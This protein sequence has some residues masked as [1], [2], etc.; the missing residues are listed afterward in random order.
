MPSVAE[1]A[2]AVTAMVTVVGVSVAA[3]VYF[4]D[5][6]DT[7][8]IPTTADRDTSGQHRY[9]ISD[10]YYLCRDH[11]ATAVN[12]TVRNINVDSHSSRY[13]QASNDNLVFIDVQILEDEGAGQFGS[14]KNAKVECRVS[15]SSN[16]IRSFQVRKS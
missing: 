15:A 12:N 6:S 4:S 2:T 9:V 10:A 3:T 1:I 5:G 11:I 7:S 8:S 16:E 13:D 14:A